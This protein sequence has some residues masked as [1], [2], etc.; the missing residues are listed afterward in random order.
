MPRAMDAQSVHLIVEVLATY[1]LE[2][3]AGAEPQPGPTTFKLKVP[4]THAFLIATPGEAPRVQATAPESM[5]HAAVIEP[6]HKGSVQPRL[7][8][9]N[10][11]AEQTKVNAA[12]AP[13]VAVLHEGDN[14]QINAAFTFH[15]TLYND[16]R[17]GAPRAGSVGNK[18]CA[19]C[20]KVLEAGSTIIECVWCGAELHFEGEAGLDCANLIANCP[21]CAK[22]LVKIPSY[23]FEPIF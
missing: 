23:T 6:I 5:E 19:V 21:C 18:S 7:L 10:S 16:P 13:R 22:S 2:G 9:I 12:I 3:A 20:T 8:V 11:A 4:N 14:F 15:V 17:I 1:Q